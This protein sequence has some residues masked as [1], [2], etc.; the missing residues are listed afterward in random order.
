MMW[1]AANSR[2]T[3]FA[4][5]NDGGMQNSVSCEKTLLRTTRTAIDFRAT[6]FVEDNRNE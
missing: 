5:D 2:D 1:K 3:G 4:E 6:G